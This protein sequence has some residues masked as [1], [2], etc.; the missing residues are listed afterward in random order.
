MLLR[1]ILL[2]CCAAVFSTLFALTLTINSGREG[3]EPYSVMHI[4]ESFAFACASQ[5]DDFDEVSQIQCLL[6]REPKENFEKM[7]T[8]FFKVDSFSKNGKYYIRILPQAKMKALPIAHR[9]FE[10]SKIY[11]FKEHTLSRHW[12][13][14][15]YKQ[16]LPLITL[17]ET[18][19]QGINFPVEMNEVAL[20]SVGALDISG[21][22]I[23]LDQV[24]DVSD[25]MRIKSAYAAGNYDHL[26]SDVDAL[27]KRYPDTI[28]KAELLLYKMRGQHKLNENEELL[29]VSKEFIR[30]Y[31]DDENMAEVLAYTANAYSSVGLQADG[32]Y[33]YERL[34]KEFPDS[35]FAA[36]GMVFLG[37][38]YMGSGKTRM[39]TNYFE[40]ALYATQD[41]EVAS[42]AAIRLAKINLDKGELDKA[43]ELYEKIIEGNG[44]YLLY[45][46]TENY[47]RARAFANRGKQKT[48]AAILGAI[49]DNL[50]HGDDR[51]EAMIKDIGIW[52]SETEDKAA[53][54]KALKRYQDKYGD[55][56][57]SEEVQVALDSLFYTPADANKSA[58]LA[59]YENLESKYANQ[60]IGQKAALEKARLYYKDK[61]YQSVLDM[62]GSGVEKEVGYFELEHDS[63]N[64]LALIKLDKGDCADAINL[65]QEYNLSIAKKF[66]EKLYSCA[67]ETGRYELANQTAQ[68]HLKD[69]Q[70]RLLWLYNYAKTLSKK[71]EYKELIE[72]TDDVITL[73]DIENSKAYDDILEEKFYAY[74]R[75]GDTQGMI[76]TAKEIEK[77]HGIRY[78]EIE[79]Y[80]EMIKLGLKQK[81]DV[82][83]QT[84]SVKVMELQEKSKSYSQT[85]FVEFSALQ[86][87][88]NQNDIKA[89]KALL[90]RLVKHDLNE[91]D[92]SRVQYML[93]SLLMKE[94]KNAEAKTAFEA[95]INSDDSSAW[96]GLSK[97]AL[98]LLK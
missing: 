84:Y 92:R 25:Y 7:K 20:P 47:D 64:A 53:A 30:E 39:S 6:P 37:D 2:L 32:A 86:V 52:L 73:A 41:V 63:A 46:I 75:L 89:Q 44:K 23:R 34:F 74:R 35:K 58:L 45:D 95:S 62:E 26:A 15:G 36:L 57:Y 77:R 9:L 19:S 4:K 31:S 18:P 8:H 27:L 82:I 85:P 69:K 3:N 90:D 87:Y 28:F 1:S 10:K 78:E 67:F 24:P 14:I 48:A 72:V 96:A 70:K 66:D 5:T 65:A 61:Q 29:K 60:E 79:I 71:G 17:D 81:D 55:S 59:E 83:I 21:K 49:T 13:I 33:F 16:N 11:H 56:D 80:V 91:K 98:E 97:D 12:M 43:A 38:Q 94:G 76:Q 51:Y 88:K 68:K 50:S 54:Y 40:R 42:M 93:G 22:P